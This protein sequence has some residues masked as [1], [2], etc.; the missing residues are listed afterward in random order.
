[1][2]C[3]DLEEWDEGVGRRFKR[4]G[5]YVYNIA[6]SLHGTTEINTF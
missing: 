4:D 3:D 1:M 6:D 5:I 2:L